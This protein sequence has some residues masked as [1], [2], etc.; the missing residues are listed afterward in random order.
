MIKDIFSVLGGAMW[1]ILRF[2]LIIAMGVG[3][4]YCLGTLFFYPLLWEGLKR[5][6]IAAACVLGII[7]LIRL[8]REKDEEDYDSMHNS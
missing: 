2:I 4:V 3:G 7:F 1:L 5:L 8:G 6:A